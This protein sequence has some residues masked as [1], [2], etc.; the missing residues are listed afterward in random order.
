MQKYSTLKAITNDESGLDHDK[1][2]TNTQHK[3]DLENKLDH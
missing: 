3:D 2:N 1:Q